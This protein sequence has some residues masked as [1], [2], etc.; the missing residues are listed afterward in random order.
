MTTGAAFT[1]GWHWGDEHQR[2]AT[3]RE[4]TELYP[5]HSVNEID[6]F[7]QGTV[8]GKQRDTFRLTLQE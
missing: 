7:C 2:E 1:A 5:E 6:A 4:A 3:A 8:D